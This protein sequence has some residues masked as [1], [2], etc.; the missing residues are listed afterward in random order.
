MPSPTWLVV[1]SSTSHEKNSWGNQERKRNMAKNMTRKGLAIGV[2]GAFVA[3]GLTASPAA[4]TE[5]LTLAPTAGSGYTTLA[6][7]TFTLSTG[8]PASVPSSSYPY[9]KYRVQNAGLIATDYDLVATGDTGDT[10]ADNY[11]ASSDAD[12]SSG[13]TDAVGITDADAVILPGTTAGNSDGEIGVDNRL[14]ITPTAA[15]TA[16]VVDV[17]AWLDT[18]NNNQIDAGE[19]YSP[20]RTVTFVEASDV[21]ASV[22]MVAPLVGDATLKANVSFS[23]SNINVR[24]IDADNVLVKFGTV[25]SS[26]VLTEIGSYADAASGAGVTTNS[27]TVTATNSVR[28]NLSGNDAEW[29]SV[30]GVFEAVFTPAATTRKGSALSAAAGTTY[31]A[32]LFLDQ[33]GDGAADATDDTDREG[34]IGTTTTEAAAAAYSVKWNMVASS[35]VVTS[36]VG[37]LD[38]ATTSATGY[39]NQTMAAKLRATATESAGG[40]FSVFV[41]TDATIPVAVE[42]VP[43]TATFTSSA[44]LADALKVDGLTVYNGQTRAITKSTNAAG[45]LTFDVE[46]AKMDNSDT[47]T[48]ELNVNGTAANAGTDATLTWETAN[49]EIYNTA[50]LSGNAGLSIASGETFTQTYQVVD[51]W[52]T[53][54]ANGL[55]RVVAIDE[56][57][58]ST[59]RTT[60]ADFAV[61]EPVVDGLAT[62][63]ITDNGVGVGTYDLHAGW[64]TVG[65]SITASG[66]DYVE[67]D[68]RV[69]SDATPAT[70]T[71]SDL[72]YGS[73]QLNDA[74]GDGDYSDTGDTDKRTELVLETE[75]LG[76]YIVNTAAA[77]ASA[78]DVTANVEVTLSGTVK[79]AAGTA[80]PFAEVT[81]ASTGGFMF[82]TNSNYVT[83]SITTVANASGVFSVDVYST[84]S[85]INTLTIT[86]GA[87]SATQQLTYAGAGA[88]AAD[89]FTVTTPATAEPGRTV[90]VTV[91][92][93]DAN[94][95]GVEGASLTLSSTGPGYLI[96]TSGTTLSDG[97]FTTKLLLGA[98]DEGTA[99]IKVASTIDGDE[100][101][102]TSTVVVGENAVAAGSEKVNAGSFKGYV[103]VYAKG[104]AGQRLSAKI[105][106][107]WVIV[108]SLA[109]NFERVVD[110]TGAGVEIAVRIYIDRVL[111]DTI[112]LTTK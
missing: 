64:A 53:A 24:Q 71:L 23:D 81:V 76:T 43:I 25:N 57:S 6:G 85:G 54:P 99:V 67:T 19:L 90:D 60:A 8:V 92:V 13:D 52:G 3:A 41:G 89:D 70:I 37:Y 93:T 98:N 9:L 105:G 58:S 65:G 51:Q 75:A 100:V 69:V 30:L 74:N 20:T 1:E 87:A 82:E 50:D 32:E 77:G 46:A 12:G 48:V 103:A 2:A 33:G 44:P 101:I 88:G 102:K 22:A 49:L 104:Y 91:S 108:E 68:V 35:D 26:G 18:N 59:E 14:R 61:A 79:N 62:L 10:Q 80:V 27:T 47:L 84:S 56:T 39:T 111:I 11:G 40:T 72:A 4:A 45:V 78:P 21:T 110:F 63:T 83:D 97:T 38:Q 106:N 36:Q 17:T 42:D 107:D 109:S 7:S 16:P 5:S 94:G 15:T 66:D 95:N 34:A 29:N 112:N 96:N 55:Y 28:S 31:G 73:A 86:S